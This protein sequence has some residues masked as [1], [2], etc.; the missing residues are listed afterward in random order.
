MTTNDRKLGAVGALVGGLG[1]ALQWRL[2]LLWAVGLLLPTLVAVLP[3]QIALSERL[4][5]SVQANRIAERFDLG[6]MI[7]ATSP[8]VTD[9]ASG[10]TAAGIA[11]FVIALLLSPWLTGMVVASIRAGQSLRFGNLLQFGLREYGRMARMLAWA[12]VPLGIAFAV[13]MPVNKW[14]EKQADIA[15]VPASAD[16]AG[17]IATIVF[18]AC[19]LLAHVTIEAGRAMLAVDPSRRSAVK[20]WW[21]GL[22]MFVRRPIAVLVVYLGTLICGEGLALVLGFARTQVSAASVGG[23]L[24]GFVLVQLVVVAVAWGRVA[25]LYG[26]SALARDTQERSTRVV[27]KEAPAEAP[28]AADVATEALAVA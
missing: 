16:N 1:R 12:I 10:L 14:A 11:G 5:H 21:R 18:V 6:W 28:A 8:I 13:S 15:I 19:L 22:K 9:G 20:A 2:L 4:D 7:E 26:L 17:L 25:R 24:L 3:W 27:P 23:L